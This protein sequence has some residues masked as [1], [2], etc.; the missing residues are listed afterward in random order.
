[1]HLMVCTRIDID[2]CF[3]FNYIYYICFRISQ[4]KL[5][6]VFGGQSWIGVKFTNGMASVDRCSLLK[7]YAIYKEMV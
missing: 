4:H 6:M 3:L 7:G 2:Q 5:L 1:M